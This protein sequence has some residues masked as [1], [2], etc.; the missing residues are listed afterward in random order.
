M[1]DV[2]T[3]AFGEAV[4]EADSYDHGIAS[5]CAYAGTFVSEDKGARDR[6]TLLK[7]GRYLRC[8]V[9]SLTEFLDERS[10]P[11]R[12]QTIAQ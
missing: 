8:S 11:R 5:L 7:E 3:N 9:R 1:A 12:C 6:C 4:T 10:R 2:A